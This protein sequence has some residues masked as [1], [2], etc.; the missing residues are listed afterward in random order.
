MNLE[1]IYDDLEESFKK[2]DIDYYLIGAQARNLWYEKKK[3][4]KLHTQDID[5]VVVVPAGERYDELKK[6]LAEQKK[7]TISSSNEFAMISPEGVPIDLLPIDQLEP[8]LKFE[9]KVSGLEEVYQYG[10]IKEHLSTGHE[11]RVATLPAIIA[12]KLIA[13]DD[14][15]EQRDKDPIDIADIFKVYFDIESEKIYEKH[16]D[17]FIEVEYVDLIELAAIVI[18]REIATICAGNNALRNRLIN[19]LQQHIAKGPHSVLIRNMVLG[20]DKSIDEYIRLFK[21]MLSG[22][23]P[24]SKASLSLLALK[25]KGNSGKTTTIKYLYRS[26]IEAGGEPLQILS[27]DPEAEAGDFTVQLRIGEKVIGITSA[28]DTYDLVSTHLNQLLD[29]SCDYFVC[30]CR[31]FDRGRGTNTAVNE[32]VQRHSIKLQIVNQERKELSD[33]TPYNITQSEI[34]FGIIIDA[35]KRTD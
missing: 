22:L 8:D 3:I 27:G 26:I 21:R 1:R 18:G 32:F 13:F 16:N 35:L 31:S 19:I 10:T 15:P 7:Y 4:S 12:L 9:P 30:A 2:S 29:A 20:T 34:M 23:Q 14:R 28:G 6:Y 11:F 24:K 33:Q 25:G 5:F 17:L